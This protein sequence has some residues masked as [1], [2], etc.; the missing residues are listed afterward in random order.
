MFLKFWPHHATS[1]KPYT[2]L[3]VGKQ[4][5]EQAAQVKRPV[6]SERVGNRMVDR[7]GEQDEWV[8]DVCV[9]WSPKKKT[10]Y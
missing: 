2:Q 6:S 9:M 5:R 4:L 1:L 7:K 8:W 3:G 10:H